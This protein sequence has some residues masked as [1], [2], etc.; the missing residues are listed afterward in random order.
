MNQFFEK[1]MLLGRP[2]YFK[3]VFWR[4]KYLLPNSFLP[5]QTDSFAAKVKGFGVQTK[6]R[7]LTFF[8]NDIMLLT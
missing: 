6:A 2:P 1:P 5:M 3:L 7:S 8:L 4:H